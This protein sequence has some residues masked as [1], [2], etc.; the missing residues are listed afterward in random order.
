MY[1]IYELGRAPEGKREASI[2]DGAQGLRNIDGLVV[3]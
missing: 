2:L 3:S 1:S